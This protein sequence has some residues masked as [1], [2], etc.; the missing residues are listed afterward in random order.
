M[1]GPPTPSVPTSL[2]RPTGTR[3]RRG[4]VGLVGIAAGFGALAA[5]G[6]R[7]SNDAGSELRHVDDLAL[8]QQRLVQLGTD[9]DAGVL[10]AFA[11][12]RPPA[13]GGFDEAAR[14]WERAADD[15]RSVAAE[16]PD[17]QALVDRQQAG[18]RR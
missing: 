5:F 11:G 9:M 14:A 6:L 13:A 15:L 1:T 4:L 3:L 10:A 12:T 2:R 17:V 7:L 18:G 8:A 16:D